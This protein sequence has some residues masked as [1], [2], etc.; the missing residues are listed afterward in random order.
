MFDRWTFDSDFA[1]RDAEAIVRDGR[2]CGPCDRPSA[3]DAAGACL[4]AL[5]QLDEDEAGGSGDAVDIR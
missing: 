4:N 2:S 3:C 5:E 1:R